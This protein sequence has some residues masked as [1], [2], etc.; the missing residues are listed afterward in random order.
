MSDV[1]EEGTRHIPR[2]LGHACSVAHIV[3]AGC[4]YVGTALALR[5]AEAGHRVFGLRRDPSDLPPA[6]EGIA[7]DLSQPR[8]QRG[9]IGALPERIDFAVYCVGADSSTAAA[10]RSAYVDGLNSFLELLSERAEP[11][12]RVFFTSSTSVYG[13]SEDEWVD[14]SS[15]TQ[16]VRAAGQILLQAETLLRSSDLAGT[17]LRFG[18]I[19]GPSRTRL[20]E[21]V[22]QGRRPVA[23]HYTNRIHRD[24]AA[25]ALYHLMF[26][27]AG[28][29]PDGLYLGV[30]SDPALESDV[31]AFVATALGVPVVE[32]ELD[33]ASD[34]RTASKRCRNDRL[35]ATGYSPRVPSFR[36]G[37]PEIIRDFLD[38]REGG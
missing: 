23:G 15:A 12:Q 24:D 5:A 30:D 14:E 16:P 13:Q 17:V 31:F 38:S 36:D 10:Y 21:R 29:V 4:G 27:M 3:I 19:Y 11:P 2:I 22:S 33:P 35:L 32:P 18:G 8:S 1:E 37:Y 7:V 9:S 25:G 28:A 34:R 26:A 20:V 6:V